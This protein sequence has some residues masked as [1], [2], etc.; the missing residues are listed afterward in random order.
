MRP[1]T[2]RYEHYLPLRAKATTIKPLWSGLAGWFYTHVEKGSS[3]LGIGDS[4][5][6][7]FGWLCIAGMM[8][9]LFLPHRGCWLIIIAAIGLQVVVSA[10]LAGPTPRLRS[11]AR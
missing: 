4:P 11:C 9:S 2:R 6:E 8:A 10:F 5:Y 3:I 7:A 1:W